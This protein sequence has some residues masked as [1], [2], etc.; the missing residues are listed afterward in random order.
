[1]GDVTLLRENNKRVRE[2][3]ADEEKAILTALDPTRHVTKAGRQET[4]G[5]A[6]TYGGWCGS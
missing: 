6:P 1:M 4:G 5:I 2:I 3:R